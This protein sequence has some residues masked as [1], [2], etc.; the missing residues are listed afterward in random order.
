[1]FKG[2]VIPIPPPF[3]ESQ[4]FNTSE[5]I[6]YLDFLLDRGVTHI[7][8]TAGT[9]QFNLLPICG[10]KLLNDICCANFPNKC[11]LGIPSGN[12]L[13]VLTMIRELNKKPELFNVIVFYPER[14]YNDEVVIT[15][16]FYRVAD[17]SKKPIFIHGLPLKSGIT[18]QSINFSADL[19]NKL[20]E[21]ENIVGMKEESSSFDFGFD[22]CSKVEDKNF[23][24][25][26]AGKSAQRFSLLHQAGAQ[27]FLS[28][29]GNLY[30]TLEMKIYRDI[31]SN[32]YSEDVVKIEKPFFDTFMSIGWHKALRAALRIKGFKF[33]NIDPFPKTT[34]KEFDR[35]RQVLL[36]VEKHLEENN[37]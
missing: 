32:G 11:T 20:A 27:T 18:G 23:Q 30:P 21:H 33:Y 4:L 16:F 10:I 5:L 1:M 24:I 9:S 15:D 22:L 8:T 7:M 2:P 37:V 35:I 29:L 17:C 28:G 31:L 19:V 3:T 14:Y 26:V 13:K 25:I 6:V 34:N 12:T 36:F